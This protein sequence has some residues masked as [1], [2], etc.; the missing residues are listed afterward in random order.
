MPTLFQP[1]SLARITRYIASTP[2]HV[3]V[4]SKRWIEWA[5]PRL[6]LALR[7]YIQVRGE[8]FELDPW[9]RDVTRSLLFALARRLRDTGINP[10]IFRNVPALRRAIR[11]KYCPTWL[12]AKDHMIAVLQKAS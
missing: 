5:A 8:P 4:L 7:E 6:N 10:A 3:S 12:T 11:W 1:N 2:E 9:L